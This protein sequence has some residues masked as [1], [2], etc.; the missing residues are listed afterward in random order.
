MNGATA[1]PRFFTV[2]KII[3][4]FGPGERAFLAAL[5]LKTGKLLWKYDEPGGPST[6]PKGNSGTWCTPIVAKVGGKDQILCSM[7]TQV[8]A[9]DPK[10]GVRLWFCE[11]LAQEKADRS[12]PRPLSAEKSASRSRGGSTGRRSVSSWAAP[13]TRQL[14]TGCGWRS[15]PNGLAQ[16]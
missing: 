16:A 2:G 13:A 10:T 8:V 12:I 3:L 15:K 9:C 5:D 14:P 7:L 11:G 4:N 6:V 1:P